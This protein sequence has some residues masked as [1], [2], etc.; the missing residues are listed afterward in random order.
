MLKIKSYDT[1]M[2]T[3]QEINFVYFSDLLPQKHSAFFRELKGVLDCKRIRYGL[4]PYTNDI[5][6]R[7][8]MPALRPAGV[9][10]AFADVEDTFVLF[11]YNPSYLQTKKWRPTITNAAKVCQEIDKNQALWIWWL[12]EAT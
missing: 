7:D 8:S 11:K 12:M 3:D 9:E 10:R 2:I 6:C 4:L 5:W 1:A